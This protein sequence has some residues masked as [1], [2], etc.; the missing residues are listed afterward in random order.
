MRACIRPLIVACFVIGCTADNTDTLAAD[1]QGLAEVHV[2]AT[3]LLAASITRVRLEAAGEAQDLTFNPATNTFDG[4]LIL[5]S[6]IQTLVASAFSSDTLVGQSQPVSVNVQPG[7]VTRIIVRILDLTT[8]PPIY[9]PI[10]DSLSFPT[11]TQVGTQVTFA[12]SV[13]APVGD[14]VT[15]AWSSGCADATFSASDTPTT[16][17][18]KPSQGTCTI[19]VTATSNGFTIA[20]TFGIVV[21]P[22]GANSG[23][24]GVNGVFVSKPSLQLAVFDFSLFSCFVLSGSNASCQGT[25]ASPSTLHVQLSVFDFGINTPGTIEVSDNCGGRF[26]T[27][28]SNHFSF[29]SG[30]WLP[31]VDGGVCIVTGRTVTGDGITATLSAAILTR[32]GTPA[33]SQSPQISASINGCTLSDAA[34]PPDC[35]LPVGL[36]PVSLFGSINWLDGN[37]GTFSVT[38]DCAGPLPDLQRSDFFNTSW[39]VPSEPGRICTT[40]VHATSLQGTSS[41]VSARYTIPSP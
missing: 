34:S 9:G 10:L 40:T 20:Q 37:P 8:N 36:G 4:V 31:P 5:A 25:I 6:G 26:G 17:W 18:S 22:S 21:F 11:T 16:T 14:P 2:D 32:A 24:V 23:A 7:V 12:I 1:H 28:F 3:Q 39:T 41:A 38:D 27:S 19:D 35:T 15:Y 33:T 13:V 29:F 30:T